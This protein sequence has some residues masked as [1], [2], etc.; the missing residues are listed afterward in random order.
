MNSK[1][2]AA[3][4]CGI[5]WAFGPA[6][7]CA[8]VPS[9]D[10]DHS[11][12]SALGR[13]AVAGETEQKLR[14]AT[15]NIQKV[16]RSYHKVA[17]AETEINVERS[18]IQKKKN[19]EELKLRAMD[20]VLRELE[21]SL[22]ALSD[23]D[24]RR[25]D[26]EREKGVRFR[27]RERWK[28]QR[29]LDLKASHADLNRLMVARMEVLLEEIRTVVRVEAERMGYDLVFDIE[30]T[31]SSQVP[32][33]LFAKDAHDITPRIISILAESAPQGVQR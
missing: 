17:R 27:E 20:Q 1:I 33:L 29:A 12:G 30:G 6:S 26:L 4:F 7:H 16:F 28:G 14:T 21:G 2:A 19:Q 24:V 15:V 31:G 22:Q 18:R 9:E 23:S 11:D 3:F 32:F 10:V 25:G 13:D 5:T 8:E